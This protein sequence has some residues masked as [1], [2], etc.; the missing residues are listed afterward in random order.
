MCFGSG[1]YTT[2]INIIKVWSFLSHCDT[3][4]DRNSHQLPVRN[5]LVS[6]QKCLKPAI[7]YGI[8]ECES[9]YRQ[10]V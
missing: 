3:L 10:N 6:A 4:N 1:L 9:V 2:S 5:L 7:V 8:Y